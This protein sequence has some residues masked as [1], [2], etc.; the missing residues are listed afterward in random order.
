MLRFIP[1]DQRS[2]DAKAAAAL[3]PYGGVTARLLYARGMTDGV[4][5]EAFLH[6]TLEQLHDPFL[7]SGMSAAVKIIQ[8]AKADGV[9]TVVY[10]DYDVDGICASSLLTLAL[11]RYGLNAV[12]HIPMRS[13]GYGLHCDAVRELAK[14]YGLLVTVDL[15][16]TNHEEVRLAQS[17]GMSVI[18]TD[19]HGLALEESPADAVMNPLLGD[20]PYRRLCGTGVAFKLA[21]ALLGLDACKEYLDLA[22]LATVADIVPLTGENRVL[23]ALGLPQIEKR[24]RP[25]VKALL[26]VSGDPSPVTSDT[27]GFQLGPR[28]NAAGRI[29]DAFKGVRLMTTEDEKE[30][31]T[32]AEELDQLNTQRRTAESKLVRQA[33]EA[34]GQHDF[35]REPA[36]IIAGDDWH[37]GVIGLAAGRLCQKYA[38]P[39]CVL[40][41]SEGLLHGSLRSV[42]GVHIHHCLQAL[43]DLLLRY[44]GHEQAAGVTLSAENEEAFRTRLQAEIRKADPS[45]FVPAQFFDGEVALSDCT[46]ALYDE[47]ALLAPFGCENPAPLL[48]I[49]NA[50]MEERRAVGAEGAHLKLSLRQDRKV[51]G[52][53]A[54]SMGRLASSLPDQVDAVFSLGR[55][56][57]RGVTSLQAEVKAILP[58]RSALESA[59][60][61]PDGQ[62][63]EEALLNAFL[64]LAPGEAGEFHLDTEKDNG[65]SS[66]S[67][68]EFSEA[69]SSMNRGILAVVHTNQTAALAL[70]AGE[71]DVVTG[72]PSDP[73]CFHTLLTQPMP[74]LITGCWS[75]IWLLDG[76]LFPGEKEV[77][78]RLLPQAEC[79]ALPV[80]DP[81]RALAG[82]LDPGDERC[83]TLYKALRRGAVFS[84]SEAARLAEISAAQ[85]RTA[86]HAFAQLQ[87]ISYTES[88]FAYTLLPPQS[89]RLGDSPLLGA[90]R[91]LSSPKEA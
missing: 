4:Q 24:V 3:R 22:A 5:A 84:L 43:D 61:Q 58:C 40:S 25:G 55:N 51:L 77:W 70:Q 88:P 34:V 10:G 89:C 59:F 90:L 79:F 60:L 74:E 71:L 14:T 23:V 63:Q 69:L 8:K 20:Y 27:L 13:E 46:D 62:R 42:P 11:R 41:R 32:L 19:H 21:Q 57:F 45:C 37:V 64:C 78:K 75:Q 50:C 49:K 17:L 16:I 67:L 6:P 39:V 48:L 68:R 83:R 56:S 30:A 81:L 80:T 9:P 65:L 7:L 87:L 28:L 44:G 72:A 26:T 31:M 85:A 15:G 52:G 82:R 54:F 53:I 38:C 91:K 18:V 1:R 73:R 33:E 36:L 35:V 86:L 66:L 2:F 47:L 76:E 12:P 29:D